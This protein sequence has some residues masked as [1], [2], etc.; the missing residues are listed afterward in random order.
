MSTLITTT[1]QIGTIKDAGGNET[2]MTIDTVGRIKTPAR[3]AFMVGRSANISLTEGNSH[4][5]LPFNNTAFDVGSNFSTSNHNYVCPIAG[6]YHF[7]LNVR[8]DSITSGG[9]LRGLIYKGNDAAT[10]TTPWDTN[11][12]VFH[13]YITGGH[14]TAYHTVVVSGYFQCAA[15]DIVTAMG[16]HNSDTNIVMHNQATFSGA[17]IG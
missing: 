1:A 5:V 11:P 6:L 16:G 2:A 10:N 13:G 9:F 15:G 17:F 3:P 14:G 12:A 8:F 4:Q 7:A